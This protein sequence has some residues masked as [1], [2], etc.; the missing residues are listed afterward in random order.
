MNKIDIPITS[1]SEDVSEIQ[2]LTSRAN[3][4]QTSFDFWNTGYVWLVGFTVFFAIVIFFTQFMSIR[5]SKELVMAQSELLRAKDEQLAR[6]LQGKDIKIVEAKTDAARATEHAALANE[7]AAEANKKAEKE[8]LE[9]IKLEVKVAWRRL[10][11]EQHEKMVN[12]LSD[13]RFS[14]YFE[15]S[16]SDPEAVQFAE[17]IFKSLKVVTGINVYPPHPLTMPPAPPGI[18]VS[19]SPNQNKSALE[20]ALKSA[21]IK[22]RGVDTNGEPR[23]SIGSK[24]SPF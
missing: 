2:S 24:P 16:Q 23:I 19:G 13:Q 9:R 5:K 3:E 8:R 20:S 18:T 22:F 10:S 15:Y 14:M 11:P 4:L 6:D 7:R 21:G 12:A 1:E 17:D